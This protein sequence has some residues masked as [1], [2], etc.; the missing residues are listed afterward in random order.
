MH[1]RAAKV[2]NSHGFFR[3][4][5]WGFIAAVDLRLFCIIVGN[6]IAV[7][8][9]PKGVY[10][11]GQSLNVDSVRN[12]AFREKCCERRSHQTG[13]AGQGGAPALFVAIAETARYSAPWRCSI[14][15]L[16]AVVP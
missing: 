8:D 12:D 4:D 3:M 13:M 2:L 15:P 16:S 9:V 10:A 7:E 1:C 14:G 6:G 11:G 5:D